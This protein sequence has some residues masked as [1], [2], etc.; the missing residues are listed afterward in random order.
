M[1]VGRLYL[2]GAV[3]AAF[4]FLDHPGPL[5]F[6]H[7]GG[8]AEAPE[9]SWAAFEHAV[10]LG[11]CYLE[12]D[13]RTSAD[14]VV[15]ALHDPT[16]DRVTDRPGLLSRMPWVEVAKARLPDGR[17]IPRLEELL[18]SWPEARWNIDVKAPEAVTPVVDVIRRTGSVNRVLLTAFAGRRS[19]QARAALGPTLA[20][21]AGRGTVAALVAAKVGLRT[22]VR[23]RAVAAQVPLQRRGIPIVDG[24]FVRVC[25]QSGLAVHVWTI[26]DP[27]VMEKLLD[28]GVDGIMTDQPST[29]KQVLE[30]R[31]QWG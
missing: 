3:A 21:G 2:W 15:V 29:L 26:D 17:G 1:R 7:R 25:H 18:G 8:A 30:R 23:S 24:A 5:A 20:I 31:G 27:A 12:T 13:V 16:L 4:P 19:A 14:G 9:N 10:S 28:L 11:Y 22:R 6:A